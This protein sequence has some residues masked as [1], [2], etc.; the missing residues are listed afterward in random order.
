MS[1]ERTRF[2]RKPLFWVVLVILGAL[3]L[4]TFFTGEPDYKK[5]DTSVVLAQLERDNVKKATLE[6]KE[7]V[8]SLD[9]KKPI[10]GSEKIQASI[11][12]EWTDEISEE[13][14]DQERAGDVNKFDV[15]VTEDSVF[16]TILI[17]LLP[18]V[19]VVILLLLFMSQMQ[20]GGSR[21][22]NFG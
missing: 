2:F 11:P 15:E 17:T 22:L 12:A 8:L 18:V 5:V 21:V 1:M 14:R 6:D 19:V 10:Q 16:V 20:G 9:L 4:S 7:Q 13:I 3:L